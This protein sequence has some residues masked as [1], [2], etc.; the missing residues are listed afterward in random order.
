MTHFRQS[1][2]RVLVSVSL[3]GFFAGCGGGGGSASPS[4]P[5]EAVAQAL[6]NQQSAGPY[7][8]TTTLDAGS[9]P[10]KMVAEVVPPDQLRASVEMTDMN[11]EMV[12]IGD[13]GWMKINDKW[14]E[15]PM[16]V[17]DMLAQMNA[18]SGELLREVASDVKKVGTELVDGQEAVIYSYLVDMNKSTKMTMDVKSNV[19][20]WITA[21]T[22]LPIRQEV[23]GTA[24][25]IKSTTA[26]TIVYDA[27]IKITPPVL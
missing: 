13:K 10:M 9:G 17:G 7:R 5:L 14:T 2:L 16:K 20:L 24:M 4:D 8:V 1:A 11:Q 25:G 26:Q 15:S 12:F 3:L 27:S 22:A 18:V 21:K 6:K 23:E 19:K